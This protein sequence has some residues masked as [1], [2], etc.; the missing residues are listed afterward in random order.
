MFVL[1]SLLL[2]ERTSIPS[3]GT[4]VRTMTVGMVWRVRVFFS[5]GVVVMGSV[6]VTTLRPRGMEDP[7]LPP[8][9]EAAPSS[10]EDSSRAVC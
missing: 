6:G 8:M 9:L 7:E 1:V 2:I 4:A 3:W 10:S 5:A